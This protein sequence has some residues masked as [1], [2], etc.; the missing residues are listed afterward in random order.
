M[1]T[2]LEIYSLSKGFPGVQ[3]LKGVQFELRRGEIHA[4]MGENGAGKSTLIKVLTGVYT[5]DEGRIHMDGQLVNAESPQE[6]EQ[7]G[8][9]T[10]YQEVNLI[11]DLSVAENIALGRQTKKW[12]LLNWSELKCRARKALARLE[13]ELDVDAPLSSYSLANAQMVAI[14]RALDVQAKLLI[15][16]EPTSSLNEKEVAELFRVMRQLREQGTSILFVTHFLEQ[17]YE[18][19]DRISVLRNG[20]H[21][22]TWPTVE[23][24][25]KKLISKML[26]REVVFQ[27]SQSKVATERGGPAFLRAEQ[28][29]RRGQIYPVDL[30]L[31]S[32]EAMG[33]AGLL[34][35]G[36][37]ELARL[38][39]AADSADSGTLTIDSERCQ[40]HEPRTAIRKGIAFL[41]EDRKS[42]G[43]FPDLSI[44]E[45]LCIALQAVRGLFRPL[46]RK[47]QERLTQSAIEKL[48]IKTPNGEV[49]IKNLSGGNQQKVLLARWLIMEPRLLI[50]DEPTRGIDIGAKVEIETIISESREKGMALLFISSDLEELVRNCQ[51][52][53]V[54]RDRKKVGEL[55]GE[56]IS[57]HDIL[58]L[59]A[60]A[61]A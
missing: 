35:S 48:K 25:E 27:E 42:E 59:I 60:E 55:E 10:V 17:V 2:L 5:R 29:G 19:C 16:D 44:R 28:L 23:L 15:L 31:R 61:S 53:A 9:S 11:P 30:E 7:A 51:R 24:N 32:G 1:T 50:L 13:L 21:V 54:M 20:E 37:T 4:L 18:V 47:E 34:G 57:T 58:H 43:I 8:I 46:S 49:M 3:A 26:G 38:F 45:N 14:A 6:A 39:F 12:G 33:L 56:S 41:S 36:R 22:G 52:I 40:L